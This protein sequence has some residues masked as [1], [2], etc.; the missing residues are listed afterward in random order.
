MLM[1]LAHLAAF[2]SFNCIFAGNR[3]MVT[4]GDAGGGLC[5]MPHAFSTGTRVNRTATTGPS[6]VSALKAVQVP[7]CSAWYGR[8]NTNSFF[9]PST[10]SP[11]TK[12]AV[13]SPSTVAYLFAG[14]SVFM[15]NKAVTLRVGYTT[16]LKPRRVRPP[17]YPQ[18]LQPT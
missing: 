18:C 2:R 8:H 1:D 6:T 9:G 3:G 17:S 4:R 7:V 16:K 10:F 5:R 13:R 14:T 15:R 12:Q 11:T